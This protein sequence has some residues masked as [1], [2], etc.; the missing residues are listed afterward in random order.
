[1]VLKCILIFPLVRLPSSLVE[2]YSI[3]KKIKSLLLHK[4]EAAL[5]PAKCFKMDHTLIV[6]DMAYVRQ[7]KHAESIYKEFSIKKNFKENSI[8]DV[9]RAR[10]LS[11]DLVIK[12]IVSTS[13]IKKWQKLLSSS[14]IKTKL[15]LY[16]VEDWKS[17]NETLKENIFLL[18]L[19]IKTFEIKC[20]KC[21]LVTELICNNHE[22]DT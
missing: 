15:V 20:I 6:D 8:K 4:L 14:D 9:G 12:L 13:K 16:L 21:C 7:L 18:P 1:M 22:A 17:N 11:E 10:R 5:E 3:F 2:A 19:R